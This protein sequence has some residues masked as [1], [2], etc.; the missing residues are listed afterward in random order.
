MTRAVPYNRWLWLGIA[1]W[2]LVNGTILGT[3]AWWAHENE[4]F[5]DHAVH[6]E[7]TV[8][9][10]FVTVSHGRGGPHYTHGIAYTYRAGNVVATRQTPVHGYVWE[11]FQEGG[12]I[13]VKYLPEKP[14]DSRID[15]PAQ[16]DADT[17]KARIGLGLGGLILLLG[18]AISY[19]AIGRNRLHRR[20]IAAGDSCVGKITS[21][22]VENTGK[23][24][25]TYLQL[26]FRDNFNRRIEGRTW[27]LPQPEE[28]HWQSG[29]PVRV[30]YDPSNS[31]VFTVDL[32]R[33]A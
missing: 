13:P 29:K 18:A 11:V 30:Y 24:F 27:D 9:R 32:T 22:E 6:V 16:D 5:A 17:M 7:G 33:S 14:Q 26:E 19:F 20:L 21:V 2:L 28:R 4:L 31:N 23:Q 12:T 10:K 3:G 25:R 8:V 1:V 15:E